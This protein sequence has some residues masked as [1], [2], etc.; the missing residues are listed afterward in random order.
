[1]VPFFPDTVY[2]GFSF[3]LAISPNPCP[4]PLLEKI[5]MGT[6]EQIYTFPEMSTQGYPLALCGMHRVNVIFHV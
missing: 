2:I 4:V 5:P 6:R 1:V 3:Y